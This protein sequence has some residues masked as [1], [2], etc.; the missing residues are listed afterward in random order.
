MVTCWEWFFPDIS[1]VFLVPDILSCKLCTCTESPGANIC[2][3]T[4]PIL[5]FPRGKKRTD[6]REEMFYDGLHFLKGLPSP[7]G[8]WERVQLIGELL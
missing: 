6:G 8:V 2:E 1:N 7:E 4:H 5:Q 3:D